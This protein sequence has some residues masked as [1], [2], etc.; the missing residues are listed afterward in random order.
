[1]KV[2]FVSSTQ[3]LFSSRMQFERDPVTCS[4]W[5]WICHSFKHAV[6]LLGWG[7]DSV[8][9]FV[10]TRQQKR[11]TERRHSAMEHGSN[12]EARYLS[13]HRCL[14]S[15]LL[16]T[17]LLSRCVHWLCFGGFYRN[18]VQTHFIQELSMCHTCTYTF[19]PSL[20]LYPSLL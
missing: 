4:Y 17:W 2:D 20:G 10:M 15:L 13:D 19:L 7:S 5:W 3:N 6:G 8:K 11:D 14:Y 16:L 18:E 1:M 9:V 12:P